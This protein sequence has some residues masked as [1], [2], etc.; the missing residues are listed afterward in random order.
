MTRYIV[1]RL[2]S[3]APVLLILSLIVFVLMRVV[4]GDPV[5]LMLGQEVD[6]RLAQQL[7]QELGYT[8][9][10][11][12][13]YLD[14]LGHVL[15]GDLGW[16][17]RTP[18]RVSELIL[19]RLPTTLLLA[20]LALGLALA[21]AVP[22]GVLASLHHGRRLDTTIS[23][24][25]VFGLSMPNFWLGI[26]L[27]FLFALKL[28]WLPSS[29]YVSPAHDLLGFARFM[30]L[31][32]CT[33]SVSYMAS[34]T[35]YV[36]ATM[37][38]V[39]REQY[40]LVARSK[41]LTATAVVLRHAFKNSLIPV[42]TLIGLNLAGLFSGAVVTETV[43]AL[44]GVGTL[45]FNAILGR[46]LPVVQGVVILVSVAVLLINIVV[47]VLYAYVDPRIRYR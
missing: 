19:L 9:P 26:V 35:R 10:V 42:I 36:R 37:L 6:L 7:R 32:V 14:W 25:V 27:I 41:G 5:L 3:A 29:G 20:F 17:S 46:D 18:F 24:G 40:V 43:F 11:V 34:L 8:R 1:G 33:L 38:D 23:V 44:P 30:L 21:V 22:A 31:P 47:D 39:F 12:I 13:Q 45:L 28:R 4:L 15:R 16:S 2:V